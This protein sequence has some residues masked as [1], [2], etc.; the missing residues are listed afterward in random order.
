MVLPGEQLAPPAQKWPEGRVRVLWNFTHV[1][2]SPHF[3]AHKGNPDIQGSIKLKTH[4]EKSQRHLSAPPE[5]MN[6]FPAKVLGAQIPDF[7][8]LPAS[9]G[10]GNRCCSSDF[11][12]GEHPERGTTS[13]ERL[14]IL[15]EALPLVVELGWLSLEKWRLS[16]DTGLLWDMHRAL[17]GERGSTITHEPKLGLS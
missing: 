14:N 9:R 12:E 10:G 17:S 7:S 13:W 6:P 11:S 15:R 16:Q 2:M 1:P 5:N 3:Q 8:S 4:T